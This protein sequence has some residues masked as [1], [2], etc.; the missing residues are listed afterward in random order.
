M[1][2]PGPGVIR[3]RMALTGAEVSRKKL[4]AYQYLPV[5]LAITAAMEV[6]GQRGK[7]A[8]ITM[9][10]EALDSLSGKRLAAIVQ[11]QGSGVSSSEPSELAEQDVYA[12]LDFWAKKI[13]NRLLY[14]K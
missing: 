6:A 4:K 9:E 8:I 12:V 7:V 11:S 10:G 3:L 5:T 14:Q 13:K 2:A 1:E